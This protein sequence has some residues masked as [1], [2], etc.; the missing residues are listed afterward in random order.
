MAAAE[1]Q[2]QTMQP[3]PSI[4]LLLA[5]LA[6]AST[7]LL[8]RRESGRSERLKWWQKLAGIIAFI[9]VVMIAI[10]PEFFALGLFG[11]TAFFDLFV[12]LISIQLQFV[13]AWAWNWGC[14]T[15]SKLGRWAFAPSPHMSYL[16]VAWTLGTIVSLG[17]AIHR[18]VLRISS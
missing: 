12:L 7:R 8:N 4:V 14:A 3:I 5:V 6:Y 18:V 11:E 13:V 17:S 10:N 15:G 16:L 9:S 2:R 1:G